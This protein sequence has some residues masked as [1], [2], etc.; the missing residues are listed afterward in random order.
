MVCLL[1]DMQ[2]VMQN[3]MIIKQLH[4]S[5]EEAARTS[6]TILKR[7]M[8]EFGLEEVGRGWVGEGFYSKSC[9]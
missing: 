8:V 7:W 1:L 4:R 9:R 6:Y 5:T 2:S 3:T